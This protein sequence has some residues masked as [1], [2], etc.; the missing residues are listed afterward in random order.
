MTMNRRKVLLIILMLAATFTYAMRRATAYYAPA[1][2]SWSAGPNLPAPRSQSAILINHGGT[3]LVIGGAT[4]VNPNNPVY[5]NTYAS[6]VQWA[7]AGTPMDTTR[8]S[9]GVGICD[10]VGQTLVYGGCEGVDPLATSGSSHFLQGEAGTFTDLAAMSTPRCKHAYATSTYASGYGHK[11]FAIGGLDNNGTVL[12]SVEYFTFSG[13]A[14]T[15]TS[16]APLPE[17]RYAFGAVWDGADSIYTCGGAAFNNPTSVSAN[18]FRYTLSTDTWSE[19]APMLVATRESAVAIAPNGHIYV[20]GGD[21]GTGAIATVQDY[22]PTTDTWSLNVS[23]PVAVHSASAVF[24]ASGRL[25]VAGGIDAAGQSVA[26]TWFGQLL[27]NPVVAPTFTSVPVTTAKYAQPY[28]YSVSAAGNP[29]P[30]FSLITAPAGMTLDSATGLMTWTPGIANIGLTLVTVRATNSAGSADQSFTITTLAPPPTTPSGVLATATSE[31]DATLSWNPSTAVV[32]PITYNLYLRGAY[33]NQFV[34]YTWSLSVSGLTGTSY[35]VSGLT[36][37]TTRYYMVTAVAGGTESLRSA[38][39]N[40]TTWAPQR[41]TG[42]VVSSVTATSVTLSWNAST[43][44]VPVVGYRIYEEIVNPTG[45]PFVLRVN[46]ITGTTGT[47]TGLLPNTTHYFFVESYDIH[48]HEST[49]YY[50][51]VQ[52]RTSSPPVLFHPRVF[53][54]EIAAAVIGDRLML[55]SPSQGIAVGADYT[56]SSSNL[57]AP[58]YSM[59]AGPPGMTIDAISGRVSWANVTGPTG[60]FSATVRGTNSEGSGDF[61]FS[62]TVYPAGTDLL[63]PTIVTGLTATGVTATAATFNWTAATDNQGVAGYKIYLQTPPTKCIR[64]RCTGGPILQVGTTNGATT[65]FNINT[66]YRGA[67]YA[68][69]VRAYDAAGNLA[70]SGVAVTFRTLP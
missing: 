6:P 7:F 42:Q 69:W 57:P 64:G 19:V 30:T 38:A 27:A 32:A 46:A 70:G 67:T 18:V 55:V 35:T 51:S 40:F 13:T 25:V 36:P 16:V 65:T 10:Y 34:G 37:G 33:I 63:A 49:P 24:E 56:V 43:G 50:F 17:A 44:P 28:L 21:S 5:L 45:S 2:L 26:L 1:Q 53:V 59:V 12:D 60:V 54:G 4:T 11:N 14:G 31:Y 47:V 9:P 66:L 29:Q 58:T 48:N 39:V 61:T 22:D 41:P 8:I 20:I 62:Y 23:L 52:A 15:W 68:L 3:L